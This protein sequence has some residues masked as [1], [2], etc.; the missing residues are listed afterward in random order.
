MSVP[1][2]DAAE[3]LRIAGE[4]H[5]LA[6]D[7]VKRLDKTSAYA[8]RTRLLSV[9]LAV[10]TV[11]VVVLGTA[12]AAGWLNLAGVHRNSAELARQ[13]HSLA[14]QQHSLCLQERDVG[15]LPVTVNP[16]TGRASL[17]GVSIV[18]D[19]RTAWRGLHCAGVLPPPDP[20]FTRWARFYKL[21]A[22]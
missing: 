14:R 8:R 20:S 12:L 21:P 4:V 9:V 5:A 16:V 10:V 3:A 6:G 17:L 2:R 7:I 22:R 1:G 13:Q 18:A 11:A 19:A 15:G